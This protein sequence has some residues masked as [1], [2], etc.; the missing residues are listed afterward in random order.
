MSKVQCRV[1]KEDKKGRSYKSYSVTLPKSV[2]DLLK[3]A[4]REVRFEQEGNRIFIVPLVDEGEE[5]TEE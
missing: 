2:V 5:G 1:T 3:L 4:G